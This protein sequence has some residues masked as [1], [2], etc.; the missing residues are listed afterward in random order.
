[1]TDS[2]DAGVV[3]GQDDAGGCD[4]D[5]GAGADGD[6]DV[7]LGQGGGVVDAVADH[8]DLSALGLQLFD[9]ARPCPRAGLRR[10]TVD[11]QLG[12]NGGGHGLGVAG[13]HRDL[14]AAGVQRV[15]G[16]PGIAG[17]SRRQ[18]AARR[19]RVRRPGRAG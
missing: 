5:V 4:G 17:G 9:L 13:D 1:M 2:T 18:A 3:A 10:S 19:S 16:V 14:D 6:A 15:N 8:G 7:G 12:S 11:A